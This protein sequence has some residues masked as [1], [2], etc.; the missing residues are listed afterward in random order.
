MSLESFSSKM[1]WKW[2]L[3]CLFCYFRN[4]RSSCTDHSDIPGVFFESRVSW[5]FSRDKQQFCWQTLCAICVSSFIYFHP[6]T[7]PYCK[8]KIF[9]QNARWL[10]LRHTSPRMPQEFEKTPPQR[11]ARKSKKSP[12]M[13]RDA[14][15]HGVPAWQSQG[16]GRDD[17]QHGSDV[18]FSFLWFFKTFCCCFHFVWTASFPDDGLRHSCGWWF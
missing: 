14:E 12:A 2:C 17:N 3:C 8:I 9:C 13:Q 1:A 10:V 18:S 7:F 6:P 15:F 5:D 16:N 11:F 4:A